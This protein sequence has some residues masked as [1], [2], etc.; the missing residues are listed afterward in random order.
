MVRDEE[1][2]VF[3]L[4]CPG[5]L[6]R[7]GGASEDFSFA[8][9]GLRCRAVEGSA[10]GGGVC[11]GVDE[12]LRGVRNGVHRVGEGEARKVEL[13]ALLLGCPVGARVRW[14][15]ESR[16]GGLLCFF[17]F[18]KKKRRRLRLSPRSFR[19]KRVVVRSS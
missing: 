9:Q 14:E 15:D 10:V 13:L 18:G 17:F 2:D 5:A 7:G 1:D 19:K 4:P 11:R 12:R 8:L 3:A 16:G 6:A